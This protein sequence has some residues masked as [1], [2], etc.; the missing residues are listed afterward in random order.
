[1]GTY[2][3][4][5]PKGQGFQEYRLVKIK[6]IKGFICKNE[7]ISYMRFNDQFKL[8]SDQM[9][10]SPVICDT[11]DTSTPL[12]A[13]I[14]KYPALMWADIYKFVLQGTCGWAHLF[15]IKDLSSV[16]EY[17]IKEYES[18]QRPLVFDSL[19][20]LLDSQ[21]KFGRINIRAYKDLNLSVESLWKLMLESKK[22]IPESTELFIIRW[23]ALINYYQKEKLYTT[24]VNKD[25][26]EKWLALVLNISKQVPTSSEM[27]LLSHSAQYRE[28]YHPS[29]R[30]VIFDRKSV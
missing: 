1:M 7:K 8:Y 27:P 29:Y 10:K 13:H 28:K 30:I 15:Q 25:A 26:L 12:L 16:K 4:P 2:E 24:K 5:L 18:A 20:E 6:K 11:N 3:L 14:Q 9:K 23:K 17:L 19:F 21:T 22:S